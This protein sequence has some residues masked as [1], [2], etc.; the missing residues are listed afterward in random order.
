MA[1][2]QSGCFPSYKTKRSLSASTKPAAGVRQH[3]TKPGTTRRYRSD[4][5]RPKFNAKS[6]DKTENKNTPKRLKHSLLPHHSAISSDQPSCTHCPFTS[7]ISFLVCLFFFPMIRS[8][9][10]QVSSVAQFAQQ[11]GR[12]GRHVGPEVTALCS[13]REEGG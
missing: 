4:S 6:T 7:F 2:Q 12:G 11:W 3:L 10:S 5:T 1:F 13:G 9:F 8:G